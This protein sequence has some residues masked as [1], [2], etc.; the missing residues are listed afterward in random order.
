MASSGLSVHYESTNAAVVSVNGDILT[1]VGLGTASVIAYQDGD[2]TYCA[3]TAMK[4]V[5]VRQITSECDEF[6]LYSNESLPI[7]TVAS[8]KLIRPWI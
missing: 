8:Q 4:A 1:I 3:T 2:S 6:A 5:R 7:M